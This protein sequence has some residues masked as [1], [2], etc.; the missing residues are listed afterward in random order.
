MCSCVYVYVAERISNYK[1]N[2]FK[3]KCVTYIEVNSW[4]IEKRINLSLST[5]LY[6]AVKNKGVSEANFWS[7][8]TRSNRFSYITTYGK[9]FD[10]L[11]F[12]S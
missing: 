12:L 9:P 7:Y 8:I 2:S 6:N 5:W 1:V 4:K 3:D 10:V 11:Q